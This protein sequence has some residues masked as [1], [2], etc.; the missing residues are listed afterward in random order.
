MHSSNIYYL[1]SFPAYFFLCKPSI[2][3]VPWWFFQVNL[4]Y[5][6]YQ[7]LYPWLAWYDSIEIGSNMP[8]TKVSLTIGL[9]IVP[10]NI[11][12]PSAAIVRVMNVKTY[13][14]KRSTSSGWLVIRYKIVA[15]VI[16]NKTYEKKYDIKL[17]FIYHACSNISY[18]DRCRSDLCCQIICPKLVPIVE[19]FLFYCC[20][21]EWNYG[22]KAWLVSGFSRVIWAIDFAYTSR[23]LASLL[24]T[25]YRRLRSSEDRRWKRFLWHSS[26]SHRRGFLSVL[27]K[28]YEEPASDA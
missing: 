6:H 18:M 1:I 16:E 15:N 13:F 19:C 14:M 3:K 27:H 25:K 20:N 5:N 11:P 17:Y 26:R 21:F 22:R 10:R 23:R 28:V 4:F 7:S 12:K 8:C 9:A 24:Y 2:S